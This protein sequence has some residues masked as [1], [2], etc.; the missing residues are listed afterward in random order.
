MKQNTSCSIDLEASGK[1]VGH[2]SVPLDAPWC[3]RDCLELPICTIANGNGP[4][5]LLLGGNH[6]DEYEGPLVLGQLMRELDASA[7]QGRLIIMPALNLPAVL[8][9]Q[10]ESPIDGKNLNR[11][12]PGDPDGTVTERIV[13]WLDNMLLPLADVFMDLHTGGKLLE[14]APL[15]MCHYCDDPLQRAK[16]RAAQL[17]FNAPLSVELRL[18]AG[19]AT[20]AARAHQRGLLVVG[21]ES[22]GG[23]PVSSESL[24]NCWR[25]VNNVLAHLQI[26]PAP[27]L[28]LLPRQ[29][30]RF[31]RKWGFD[32]EMTI[33]QAGIFVPLHRLFDEVEAGQ[34]AG[35]LYHLDEPMRPAQVVCFPS[36][37]LIAGR[38][39]TS[40]V[41]PGDQVYWIVRDI[42]QDE[43]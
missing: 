5:V 16:A 23:H 2:V 6:G 14:L 26:L 10:R 30:T 36:S 41:E 4:T 33:D 43:C 40:G 18:G 1:Q 7:I 35:Q 29:R 27:A 13:H 32:A 28:P 17:A 21:T 12:W 37:G 42:E 8:A 19:R 34:P 3:G 24:T 39:A 20:A 22:G 38:R 15:S 11:V 25:G 31:T 9:Q